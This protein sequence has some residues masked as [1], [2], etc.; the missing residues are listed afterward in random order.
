MQANGLLAS[1][2]GSARESRVSSNRIN[3]GLPWKHGVKW[4]DC[5]EKSV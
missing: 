2:V 1:I 3:S 5:D 4:A